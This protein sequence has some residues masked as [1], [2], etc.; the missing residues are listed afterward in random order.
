MLL[1]IL[2]ALTLPGDVIDLECR[3]D[4]NGPGGEVIGVSLS[5]PRG[6]EASPV[7]VET[8]GDLFRT[9]TT[10]VG[11]DGRGWWWEDV[12]DGVEGVSTIDPDTLAYRSER[13]GRTVA[14]ECRRLTTALWFGGVPLGD[15][16][17]A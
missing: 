1:T 10:D 16:G 5:I 4:P 15:P 12:R 11:R 2:L 6:P 7:H 14:G 13:G 8:R 3:G 9:S 17:A